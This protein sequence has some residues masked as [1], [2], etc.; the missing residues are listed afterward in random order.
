MSVVGIDLGNANT[1]IAVARNRGVDIVL[2]EASNRAT[3]SLVGFGPKCRFLGEAAK[4]MEIGNVRNTV[5]SLKRLCGRSYSDPEINQIE[6]SFIGAQLVDIKGQV[7]AKVQYLGKEEEFT[8]TQLLASYFTKI[9]QITTADSKGVAVSDVVISV[10]GWFTD[11]Q[12]RSI[13]DAAE[14]AELNC[15][16]LLNDTTASALGYGITKT[17]LPEDKPRH[18]AIVDVGHSNMSVAIV[19]FKKGQLTVLST[20][21]DRHLGGRDFDKALVDHF[22]QVFKEKYK[23]DIN[24]NAKAL[25]RVYAAVEKLKKILSANAASPLNIESVMNDIDA[26]SMLKRE[27]LEQ[28]VAPLLERVTAPLETALRDAKLTQADIDSVEMVGGSTRIPSLKER[29]SSF[30]GKQLS[31]TLNADEAIARGAAFACAIYSPIFKVREFT[32]HDITPYPIQFNWEPTPDIPNEESSLVV[33]QRKNAIPSTKILTF[34][35][36]NPFD[37]EVEYADPSG[38]PG[39]INPW[40]ARYTIKNVKPTDD[41]DLSVVKVKARMN[42]HGV[43]N[44]E[45]AYIVAEEEVEEPIKEEKKDVKKEPAKKDNKDPD[46]MD[47]EP[48]APTPPP[49]RKV[50]K[51]VRKA[52]LPVVGGTT[53]IDASLKEAY[54]EREAEMTVADKLIADTEDRKNALE[55]YIY[56]V[57]GKLDDVYAEYASEEE[58]AKFRAML[59]AAEEWL[60]DEGE[61]TTKNAYIAKMEELLS[62]GGPIRQR[63]LD[64]QEKVRQEELRI[65][66]E[67][68]AE[69]KRIRDEAEAKKKAEEEANKPA[70]ADTEMAVDPQPEEAGK[71]E[72]VKVDDVKDE[73]MTDATTNVD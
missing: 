27:E 32:V 18:V 6:Q 17:D 39:K 28:L 19:A 63:L 67:R 5:G 38:L 59:D 11:A 46:A 7:G 3:P 31:F 48:T 8:A 61:D 34:Y 40:I 16:R 58:K 70:N 25:H 33:F 37:I 43:L 26:T 49:T 62:V 2:N 73:E 14:I 72:K 29:V 56:D 21:Y 68:A 64:A 57:R 51:Q 47:A 1:V 42:V 36:K 50:K 13:L 65:Q 9:K 41:G 24:S 23:I 45:Q 60:Y 66:A 55:E 22:A 71:A 53:S 30:F 20:A 10:P 35:R 4:T 52:D 69:I 54:K 12:R 44:V 15:L